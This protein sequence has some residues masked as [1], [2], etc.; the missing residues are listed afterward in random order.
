MTT[1]LTSDEVVF[2]VH[3]D[4]VED[5]KL[6]KQ[7]NED[8]GNDC[9]HLPNVDAGTFLQM[10]HFFTYGKLPDYDSVKRVIVAADYVQ[11]DKL[12]DHCAEYIATKIIKGWTPE[13]IRYYFAD[14]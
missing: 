11:Y 2:N 5:A 12:V 9:V 4:F 7:F 10:Q 3:R 6:L 8:I 13:R 14:L 1:V